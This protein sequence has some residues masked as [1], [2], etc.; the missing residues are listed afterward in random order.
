MP[1]GHSPGAI[2]RT[3]NG[4]GAQGEYGSERSVTE[5]TGVNVPAW[6]EEDARAEQGA[7]ESRS[8]PFLLGPLYCREG[9]GAGH[10]NLVPALPWLQRPIKKNKICLLSTYYAPSPVLNMNY[11]L[12]SSKQPWHKSPMTTISQMG[13]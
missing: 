9:W 3:H 11:L 6:A 13:H 7:P 10:T 4:A 2:N 8:A 1:K 5:S 12:E